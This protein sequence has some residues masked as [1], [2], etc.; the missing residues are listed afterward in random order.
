LKAKVA[1]D[2]FD[3]A[4]AD[5]PAGLAEFLGDDRGG[6]VGVQEAMT[7]DLADKLVGASVV[8][9]GATLLASEGQSAA[10][11]EGVAELEIALLTQA[12]LCGS[13]QGAKALALTFQEHGQFARDFIAVGNG[14]D[15]LVA[16]ELP[17]L[18]IEVEHG[19]T[20]RGGD[21][22]TTSTAGKD[23]GTGQKGL[24]KYGGKRQ[25]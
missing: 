18:E 24:I 19:N 9:F 23:S 10:A 15:T 4:R 6:S 13:P 25:D 20:S 3:R 11:V 22:E 14:E 21:G 7:N 1:D 17:E 12:E 16:N 8:A 2:P 5:G